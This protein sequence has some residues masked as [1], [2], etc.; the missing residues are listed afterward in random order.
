VITLESIELPED[1][2]WLDEFGWN[3]VTQQ[4]E[5]TTGG[6]LLIEEADQAAGR[7][8]TLASGTTGNRYWGV[9][10]RATVEAL[11]AL[12]AEARGQD[13][14]MTLVLADETE[15]QVMFR[16]GDLGFE[17]RPW[18]HVVP[19]QTNTFYLITL[20]LQIVG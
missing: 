2:E 15:H 10:N 11:A 4:V 12:A 18:K 13:D 3:P 14:P 20:R 16:H 1:L 6:S 8:V 19:V 7:P 5:V 17:A 9:V